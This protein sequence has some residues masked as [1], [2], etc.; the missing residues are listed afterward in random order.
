MSTA[1]RK[2]RV[3]RRSSAARKAVL[4]HPCSAQIS[5]I[6]GETLY[7]SKDIVARSEHMS[8]IRSR[9]TKRP[10]TRPKKKPAGLASSLVG[11]VNGASRRPSHPHALP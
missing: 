8:E 6:S 3:G 1:I 4:R 5:C 10:L 7:R 9:S 2:S 11:F